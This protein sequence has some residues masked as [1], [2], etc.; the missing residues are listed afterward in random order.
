M[1]DQ[2]AEQDKLSDDLKKYMHEQ[3][4]MP[5]VETEH[6]EG[7]EGLMPLGDQKDHNNISED[8]LKE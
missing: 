4:I 7:T 2:N 8:S 1:S 5:G 6:A 3:N